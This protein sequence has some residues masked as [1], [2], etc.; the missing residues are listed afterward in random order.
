MQQLELFSCQN[1]GFWEQTSKLKHLSSYLNFRYILFRQVLVDGQKKDLGPE[2]T[3][4][5]SPP[6]SH[7]LQRS[8][9]MRL[10]ARSPLSI[11]L[12]IT[13]SVFKI[14]S[15]NF[16]EVFLSGFRR[17]F[18]EMIPIIQIFYRLKCISQS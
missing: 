13:S 1:A 10:S 3:K 12:V 8:P 9:T 17:I 15:C 6:S 5:R 2:I 4:G 14:S 18:S 7:L 11:N 16:E